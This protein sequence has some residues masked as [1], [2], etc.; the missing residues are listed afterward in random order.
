LRCKFIVSFAPIATHFFSMD[1]P[2]VSKLLATP[3]RIVITTHRSPDGDAIG[4]SLGLYHY[5]VKGGH[6]VQ[7]VTPNNYPKFLQ[8]LPGND[9]VTEYESNSEVAAK[10]V[11]DAEIVFCLDY[12]ALHRTDKLGPV[13]GAST[14][15]KVLIDHHQQPDDFPDFS[16]SDTSASSTAQLIY[17]FIEGLGGLD[18]VDKNVAEC[19]YTGLL[20]DTG[21]FRFPSTSPRTHEIVAGL[22]RKGLEVDQVYNRI[23]DTNSLNKLQLLGYSLSE[24]LTV[25]KEYNTA[26]IG[27]SYKELQRFN[28][29]KGD[30]EG[31]VNYGLSIEGVVFAVL[32][33][34]VKGLVKMSLR[35]KG[36]F[37]VNQMARAH[38][39]G[40]GHKNAAGG[41]S[42]VSFDKTLEKLAA[43]L[44]QY[45]EALQ[46]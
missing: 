18:L 6:Q 42:D 37:D 43:L 36:D 29:Q 2:A 21:S 40:G 10:M 13:I 23:F 17:D 16:L 35:S 9:T 1:Y 19:L 5:L 39:N 24:K 33:Q 45:K 41:L 12:N 44:P 32:V 22:M 31:L 14:A 15:L 46:G 20:T 27:L 34:E 26:I 8:W 11:G 38:F 4:S 7:V 30:T 28:F 3:R 25:Y